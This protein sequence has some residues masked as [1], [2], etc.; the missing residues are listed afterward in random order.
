MRWLTQLESELECNPLQ[1]GPKIESAVF[2]YFLF[3]NATSKSVQSKSS[4]RRTPASTWALCSSAQLL[5]AV[6]CVQFGFSV[7]PSSWG[8]RAACER[9]QKRSAG[10]KAF[11]GHN[12]YSVSCHLWVANLLSKIVSLPA[13]R[14][15]KSGHSFCRSSSSWSQVQLPSTGLSWEVTRKNVGGAALGTTFANQHFSK[16]VSPNLSPQ[17]L[18]VPKKLWRSLCVSEQ[19]LRVMVKSPPSPP[20]HMSA[21][22]SPQCNIKKNTTKAL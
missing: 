18:Q 3:W 5:C 22:L 10:R 8:E 12:H 17:Q 20:P 4:L 9:A 6:G 11:L 13:I 15:V 21:N 7:P 19:S 1:K 16:A 2:I 14:T